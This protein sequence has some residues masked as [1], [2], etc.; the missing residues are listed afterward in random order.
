MTHPTCGQW[1]QPDL[2]GLAP[3]ETVQRW[4][5]RLEAL[6]KRLAAGSLGVAVAS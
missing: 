2:H 1:C 5:L 3:D 6:N 4:H